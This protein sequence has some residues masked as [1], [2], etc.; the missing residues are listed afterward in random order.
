MPPRGQMAEGGH[1]YFASNSLNV[2]E[3]ITAPLLCLF[4]L[5]LPGVSGT[6]EPQQGSASVEGLPLERICAG[7]RILALSRSWA[8]GSGHCCWTQGFSPAEET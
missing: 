1:I 4:S 5:V 3:Q 8:V 6:W 7:S 2:P